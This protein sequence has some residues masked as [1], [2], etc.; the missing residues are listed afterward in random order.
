[1]AVLKIV[2]I[3][4]SAK[5]DHWEYQKKYEDGTFSAFIPTSISA[6][7]APVEYQDFK[8]KEVEWQIVGTSEEVSVDTPEPPLVS[9]EIPR[10]D[11]KEALVRHFLELL[12]S[13]L[14]RMQG[15]GSTTEEKTLLSRM[16]FSAYAD[17]IDLGAKLWADR[18]LEKHGLNHVNK[19]A[20]SST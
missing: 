5:F 1:M 3:R 2:D 8:K 16:A 10:V 11:G 20:A 19:S 7:V 6:Y 13:L 18:L 9:V 17:L 4:W 15:G 12:D 14:S